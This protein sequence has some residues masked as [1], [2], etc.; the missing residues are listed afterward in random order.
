V[1]LQGDYNSN[2]TD[3]TWGNST[4]TEPEHAS[5]AVIADAVTLLSNAWTENTSLNQPSDANSGGARPAVTT[6]YRLA[7]AAGKT[8]N[9]PNPNW[10]GGVLY[11]YGTDGGLHNF[12]RFLESWNNDALYY[13]GSLVSLYYSAYATGTFKCCGYSVYQPPD[14]NYVFDPLFAKPD[15]LPPGTPS[16]RDVENLSYHQTFAARAN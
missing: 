9:F 4:A 16:F 3:P 13:K 6:R 2:S 5:A 11:G 12:L 15:G 7:I 8:I 1:Y 10:S 14:R